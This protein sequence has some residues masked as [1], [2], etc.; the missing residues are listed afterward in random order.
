MTFPS[1]EAESA[2]GAAVQKNLV[3]FQGFCAMKY[4]VYALLANAHPYAD[5]TECQ[6]VQPQLPEADA[7]Q[8]TT[9]LKGDCFLCFLGGIG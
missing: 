1:E 6:L 4:A 9:S 2:P 5:C 3:L 7:D 8:P